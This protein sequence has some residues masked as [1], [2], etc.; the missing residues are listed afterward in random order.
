MWKEKEEAT[1]N[2]HYILYHQPYVM[3]LSENDGKGGK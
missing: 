2:T 3:S 1:S